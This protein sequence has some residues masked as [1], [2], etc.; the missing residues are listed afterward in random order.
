MATA[1]RRGP[2]PS[3]GAPTEFRLRPDQERSLAQLAAATGL[4][5]AELVREA[6]DGLIKQLTIRKEAR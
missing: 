6:V 2:V 4:P 5:R 1:K 3:L